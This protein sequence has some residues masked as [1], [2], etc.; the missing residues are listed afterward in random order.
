MTTTWSKARI[1]IENGSGH[2]VTIDS[3][4]HS[5]LNKQLIAVGASYH[6]IHFLNA[7][8]DPNHWSVSGH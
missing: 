4:P 5:G 7:S 1:T 2:S 6:V 8:K 3:T